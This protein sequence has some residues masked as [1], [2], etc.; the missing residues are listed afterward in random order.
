MVTGPG[1]VRGALSTR[2]LGAVQ[3]SRP[4]FKEVPMPEPPPESAPRRLSAPPAV[5][6]GMST[7][8]VTQSIGMATGAASFARSLVSMTLNLWEKCEILDN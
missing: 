8:P 1:S 6:P 4:L 5:G 3:G 2:P 7:G